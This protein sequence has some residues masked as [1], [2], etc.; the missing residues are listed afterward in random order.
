MLEKGVKGCPVWTVM[1]P[2]SLPA[3]E[4]QLRDGGGYRIVEGGGEPVSYI[5]AGNRFLQV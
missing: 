2:L 1:M 3:T 5:K 4:D